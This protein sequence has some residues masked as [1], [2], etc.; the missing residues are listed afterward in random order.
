MQ[1]HVFSFE[2]RDDYPRVGELE[3]RVNGLIHALTALGHEAHFWFVGDPKRPECEIREGCHLHRWRQWTRRYEPN[4]VYEDEHEKA[5]DYPSSLPFYL[6][7][8]HILPC[9]LDG[10]RAVVIAEDWRKL[11]RFEKKQESYSDRGI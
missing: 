5:H 11:Y 8:R 7:Y 9:L 2:G 3:T 10:S 4:G 1:F 6:F